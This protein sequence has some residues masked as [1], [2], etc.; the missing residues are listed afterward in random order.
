MS[1][2][3]DELKIRRRN[4]LGKARRY[5]FEANG[6]DIL[7]ARPTTPTNGTVVIKDTMV[8]GA[9]KNGTMGQCYVADATTFEFLGMVDE[10][11]LVPLPRK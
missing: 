6:F 11:S 1:T 3:A 5:R 2:Y 10:R 7:D 8:V 4:V 9:P